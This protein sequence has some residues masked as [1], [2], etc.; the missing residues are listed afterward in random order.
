MPVSED[1]WSE[2]T[3]LNLSEMKEHCEV[4]CSEGRVDVAEEWSV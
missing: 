1:G 4:T 2:G 3:R